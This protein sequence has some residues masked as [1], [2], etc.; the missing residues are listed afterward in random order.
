MNAQNQAKKQFCMHIYWQAKFHEHGA[1][2]IF[3]VHLC[4][5][6]SDTKLILN[7]GSS[8]I[9]NELE[10]Y[11]IHFLGANICWHVTDVEPV[12]LWFVTQTNG[13]ACYVLLQCHVSS[14]NAVPFV[15]L[16]KTVV[17]CVLRAILLTRSC[18]MLLQWA[19]TLKYKKISFA[20]PTHLQVIWPGTF[21]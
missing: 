5:S 13:V 15:S 11:R 18:V 9:F 16:L 8:F 10:Q 2:K 1:Y 14:V 7:S 12:A 6:T 20:A 19:L 4:F 3:I 17:S 21:T